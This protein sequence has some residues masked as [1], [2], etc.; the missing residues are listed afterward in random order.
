M[1]RAAGL[2][3][4]FAFCQ[5]FASER[6]LHPLLAQG[7]L[8]PVGEHGYLLAKDPRTL[9]V[10]NVFAAYTYWVLRYYRHRRL[11]LLDGGRAA[12]IADGKN[13]LTGRVIVNRA[14][15]Q[16]FGR[17]IVE[18]SDNFGTQGAQPTHQELLD[19]LARD[20]AAR[21][22]N[23]KAALNHLV[24][25]AD[26]LPEDDE[27]QLAAGSMLGLFGGSKS[28][29]VGTGFSVGASTIFLSASE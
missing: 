29:A 23:G 16:M 26:L 25:A 22:G 7:L 17:G 8:R 6:I 27:V 20:F 24:R 11:S 19:W 4:G 5:W 9:D 21:A 1:P 28:P 10:E 15:Q 3:S 18:T 12:W 13:P 2:G 14:W